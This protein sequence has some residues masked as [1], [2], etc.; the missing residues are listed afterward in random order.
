[1]NVFMNDKVIS[2]MFCSWFRCAEIAVLSRSFLIVQFTCCLMLTVVPRYA[3]AESLATDSFQVK[4]EETQLAGRMEG[5]ESDL[6]FEYSLGAGYRKDNLT[7]S[8]AQG[9]VNV[10]SEVSWRNV[11]IAQIRAAG[12]LNLGTDW[13]IRGIYST[14]AV[15][16]GTNQDSDYAGSNRTQ[17]FSRSENRAG[18]AIRDISIGLGRKIRL[19]DSDSAGAMYI[20]PLAGLSIHQ[21][22]LTMYEG[23]QTIPSSMPISGL[24]NSYDTRWKGSW[25]GLD[26]LLG[27]GKRVSLNATVEWHRVDYSAEANWNLRNDLAHPVSFKHVAKGKGLLV[28]GGAS[29]RFSRNFLLNALVEKQKWSTSPGYDQTNF[30]YGATSFYTLNPVAWDSTSAFLGAVYQF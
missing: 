17:E 9:G 1:M 14:G 15:R 22:S 2:R 29:Y 21:Q 13:L 30:S 27:V 25:L 24:G 8:I 19:F 10:A 20:I 3:S 23:R 18:G 16:S 4:D 6:P 28:S 5:R 12:K 26:A 11:V 7:W